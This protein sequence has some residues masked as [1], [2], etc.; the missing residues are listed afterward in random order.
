M[1]TPMMTRRANFYC[2]TERR[3]G[4]WIWALPVLLVVS[5]LTIRNLDHQTP[6]RDEFASLMNV[7]WVIDGPYSPAD[8]LKALARNSPDQSPFYFLMLNLWGSFVPNDIALARVLSIYCGLLFLAFAFRLARDFIAPVC[9]ILFLMIIVS[10]AFINLYYPVARMYQLLLLASTLSLWTYLRIMVRH[11]VPATRDYIAFFLSCLV[12]ASTHAGSVFLILSVGAYHVLAA[13]KSKRWLHVVFCSALALLFYSPWAIHQFTNGLTRF[14]S[15]NSGNTIVSVIPVLSAFVDILS[16][17]SLLLV[18]VTIAGLALALRKQHQPARRF[19]VLF[20]IY[21]AII[22]F[23]EQVFGIF[24]TSRLRYFL[25]GALLALLCMVAALYSLY[26]Y[27]PLLILVAL[28]WPILG[29]AYQHRAG[30]MQYIGDLRVSIGKIP[31]HAILRESRDTRIE[32]RY[33]AYRTHPYHLTKPLFGV[34]PIDIY[35]GGGTIDFS[36]AQSLEQ[37]IDSSNAD[38]LTASDQWIIFHENIVDADETEFMKQTMENLN[39]Q[40]CNTQKF[41]NDTLVLKFGWV[42]LQCNPPQPLVS[43]STTLIHYQFLGAREIDSGRTLAFSDTWMAKAGASTD[44]YNMSYQ[45]INADWENVAQ[46]DLPLVH[47]GIPRQFTIDISHLPAGRYRFVAVLY[48]LESGKRFN[49][50]GGEELAPWMLTLTEIE[51]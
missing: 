17:G 15:V 9:G 49:W 26:R 41:S 48:E 35:S 47:E 25:P 19:T 29:L 20:L 50:S 18:F 14:T 43:D 16:N 44:Q 39:Y 31:Y 37:F 2:Q 7:G 33:I 1:V 32:P 23:F 46:L 12:L 30:W 6:S 22:I 11:R 10:N 4:H 51:L 8:A 24:N 38:A 42:T 40:L 5:L 36:S 34:R 45:L 27:K 3:F 21:L 13:P 28:L